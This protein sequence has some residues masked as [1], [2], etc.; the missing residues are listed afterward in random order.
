MKSQAAAVASAV[1]AQAAVVSAAAS[2]PHWLAGGAD[3]SAGASVAHRTYVRPKIEVPTPL[4]ADT[5]PKVELPPPVPVHQQQGKRCG[6]PC[7]FA[8][9]LGS[10]LR[11]CART[12]GLQQGHDW[13]RSCRHRCARC[14]RLEKRAVI[15]SHDVAAVFHAASDPEAPPLEFLAWD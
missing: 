13:G 11:N 9:A 8:I 3:P 7:A 15:S 2:T 4:P 5:R 6:Q 14:Y 10:K 1:K 12:C